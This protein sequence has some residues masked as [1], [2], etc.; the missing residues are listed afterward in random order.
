MIQKD[1]DTKS[2]HTLDWQDGF[3]DNDLVIPRVAPNGFPAHPVT[4]VLSP[5]DRWP[6]AFRLRVR[7][8]ELLLDG[9]A[10]ELEVTESHG[11]VVY[12]TAKRW[13]MIR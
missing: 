2:L 13:R 1:H 11:R 8:A 10:S 4:A 7:A 9:G 12:L 5:P 3:G 6:E